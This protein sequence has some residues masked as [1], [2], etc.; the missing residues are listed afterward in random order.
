MNIKQSGK[1]WRRIKTPIDSDPGMVTFTVEDN[2]WTHTW[3]MDLQ[4]KK[5]KHN[6]DSLCILQLYVT[7]KNSLLLLLF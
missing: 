4:R 5:S 1:L 6:L 2:P 7:F 3:F